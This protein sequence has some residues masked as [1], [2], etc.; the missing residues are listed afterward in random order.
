MTKIA[1][2]TGVSTGIGRALVDE[3]INQGYVVAGIAR[4]EEKIQELKAKYGDKH[5][6]IKCDVANNDEVQQF[7]K[8][9]Y[10]KFGTVDVLF[11]N[12][13][14]KTELRPLWEV[15]EQD[16]NNVINTNIIGVANIIRA[17]VPQ[18]VQSKSGLIV[19]MSSEWGRVTDAKVGAY[20][21]SK[22]AIEG[23]TH[24]LAK[25]LPNGV[26]TVVLSPCVVFTQLLEDVKGLLLPGEYEMSVTPN[27]WSNFI[28]PKLLAL[29]ISDNGKSITLSPKYQ[30]SR[31]IR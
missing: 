23:L 26:I 16:F 8:I 27:E 25:E 12:A 29:T 28:V 18:M 15:T 6:F 20:C 5:I 14:V 2:I 3:F 13:A 17:F 19:N 9:V 30:E 10:D 7:A 1:V 11:N 31:D 21:A 24:A 22:F 4:T